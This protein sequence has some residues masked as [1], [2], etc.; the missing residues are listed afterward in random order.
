MKVLVDNC[1][2]SISANRKKYQ[3]VLL[4]LKYYYEQSVVV[5]R[6]LMRLLM[7]RCEL[8]P[9]NSVNGFSPSWE[10]KSLPCCRYWKTKIDT[11]NS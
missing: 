9:I 4:F 5:R 10:L 11:M 8:M 2:K 6:I 1:K 7:C 3:E